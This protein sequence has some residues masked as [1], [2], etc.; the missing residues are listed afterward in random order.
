MLHSTARNHVNIQAEQLLRLIPRSVLQ[1]SPYMLLSSNTDTGWLQVFPCSC[2]ADLTRDPI[3]IMWLQMT[4]PDTDNPMPAINHIEPLIPL[5]GT[6]HSACLIIAIISL[7][8][9]YLHPV[10][11]TTE[12]Q[13]IKRS[14]LGE[15]VA[16]CCAKCVNC[17]TEDCEEWVQC[18]V[19]QV[20]YHC[21]C[22]GVSPLYFEV[23]EFVCC[24][25]QEEQQKLQ[26][27]M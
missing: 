7:T 15:A 24:W 25:D 19:C 3:S 27:S 4:D 22:V 16:R 11:V 14:Y 9:S 18:D 26:A 12:M 5:S 6:Q 13:T 17:E 2:Y 10:R 21:V 20:W 23:E 8:Y 1:I